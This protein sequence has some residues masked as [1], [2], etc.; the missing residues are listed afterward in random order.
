LRS[1]GESVELER[2]VKELGGQ[3]VYDLVAG[4]YA[5]ISSNG[6]KRLIVISDKIW[7][8]IEQPE[9][10]IPENLF[11]DIE[12]HEDKKQALLMILRSRR[13]VHALF[14]G[15]PGVAKT[16]F[17]L[18]LSRIE[19]AVYIIGS[20]ISKAG[21]ADYIKKTKPRILL[22]DEIDKMDWV[23][24]SSLLSLMETGIITTT[25]KTEVS[26]T[27]V[28]TK[29]IAACNRED[30][31]DPALLDRFLI[32]RFTEYTPDEFTKIV[33]KILITKENTPPELAEYIAKAISQTTK[34]VRDA[35]KI[36]RLAKT[37]EEV[38]LLLREI[39]KGQKQYYRYY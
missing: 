38:D 37:K 7:K 5:R 12:G 14:V 18:A 29:V 25:L 31:L 11:D 1:Y 36:A 2:V 10:E 30:R 6:N 26:R 22:I 3:L 32:L 34:S 13:P 15:P 9:T 17:M 24:Q 33:P 21:L 27:R 35:I 28:N 8:E 16:M 23:S 20:R 19:G 4:G 39:K